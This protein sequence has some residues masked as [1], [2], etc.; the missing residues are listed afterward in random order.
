MYFWPPKGFG[1]G[2]EIVVAER[3]SK[4]VPNKVLPEQEGKLKLCEAFQLVASFA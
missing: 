2:L 1:L 3:C 4:H